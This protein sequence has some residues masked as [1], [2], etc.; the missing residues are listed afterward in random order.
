MERNRGNPMGRT[1]AVVSVIAL[2][3][4][5]FV[6]ACSNV[7]TQ[8]TQ[9]MGSRDGWISFHGNWTATGKRTSIHLGPDR[10]ASIANFEGTLYLAG[11]AHLV[12]FRANL[13]VLNDSSTGAVGRAVWTDDRGDQIFS[14]L[15]GG[16]TA[17]GKKAEGTFIGGTGRYAGATGSYE[18]TWKFVIDSEDGQVQGESDDVTGRIRSGNQS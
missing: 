17:A 18:F 13:I 12:G 5:V 10:S 14:E 3:A 1:F 15:R 7:E 16:D 2:F 11:T 8:A 6:G 4:L 9:S